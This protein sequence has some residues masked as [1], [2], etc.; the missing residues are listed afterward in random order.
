MKK[1]AQERSCVCFL[2]LPRMK[3]AVGVI[4]DL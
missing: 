3:S 1:Q 4:L 2:F